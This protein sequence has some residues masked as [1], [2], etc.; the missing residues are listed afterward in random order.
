M[1][2]RIRSEVVEPTNTEQSA[3]RAV[4]VFC[5]MPCCV[6]LEVG[7]NGAAIGKTGVADAGYFKLGLG[8]Q[9]PQVEGFESRTR[10]E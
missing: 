7:K 10:Q 2:R 6:M 4:D 5:I 3:V 1:R 8:A 9:A